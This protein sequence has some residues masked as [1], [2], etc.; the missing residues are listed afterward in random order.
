MTF[1]DI[2]K[3]MEACG[4]NTGRI[5]VLLYFFEHM[6]PKT[7]VLKKSYN[8][9]SKGS[10][11]PFA[12]VVTVMKLCQ[13]EGLVNKCGRGEWHLNV[14]IFEEPEDGSDD[15]FVWIKNYGE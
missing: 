15:S 14:P 8:E 6:N 9:I 7:Y 13:L 11:V 10:G 5:R 12:T 4:E 3:M 1:Y 2:L